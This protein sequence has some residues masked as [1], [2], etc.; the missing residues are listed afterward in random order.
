MSFTPTSQQMLFM[1]RLVFGPPEPKL[2]EALPQLKPAALRDQLKS[3]GLIAVEKRGRSQYVRLTE[4]GW[5]WLQEHLD[6]PIN[7]VGKV[8]GSVLAELLP[9]LKTFLAAHQFALGELLLAGTAARDSGAADTPAATAASDAERLLDTLYRLDGS[10]RARILLADARAALPELSASAFDAAALA[11]QAQGRI[12]LYHLDD[13]A[14]RTP[15][16]EDAAI[17]VARTRY[18]L[19]YLVS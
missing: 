12:A 16:I 17:Q 3:L 8:A 2:S 15:R 9:R 10:R 6:A 19:A 1:L 13:P 18:H 5:A 11:L 4:K 14:Q 7:P